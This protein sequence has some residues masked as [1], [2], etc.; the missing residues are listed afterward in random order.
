MISILTRSYLYELGVDF[1]DGKNRF[2]VCVSLRISDFLRLPFFVVKTKN[3]RRYRLSV[4][5]CVCGMEIILSLFLGA[6]D[7][8]FPENVFSN[9][10]P[11]FLI[12]LENSIKS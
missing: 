10:V 4:R 7:E 12:V 5:A 3:Y 9:K 11:L 8:K 2:L 6:F 1:N